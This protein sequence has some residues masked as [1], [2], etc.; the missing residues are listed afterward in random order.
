MEIGQGWLSLASLLQRSEIACAIPSLAMPLLGARQLAACNRSSRLDFELQIFLRPQVHC[1]YRHV[2]YSAVFRRTTG[3]T[4]AAL[5]TLQ[6]AGRGCSRACATEGS[7]ISSR[8][9]AHGHNKC[10]LAVG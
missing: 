7:C 1:D 9:V 2:S 10:L 6:G 4:D 8:P 5:R 3:V